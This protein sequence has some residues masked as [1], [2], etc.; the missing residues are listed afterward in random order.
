MHVSTRVCG[1]LDMCRR[2]EFQSSVIDASHVT[3]QHNII[4]VRT[5]THLVPMTFISSPTTCPVTHVSPPPTHCQIKTTCSSG[6]TANLIVFIR[7]MKAVKFLQR[8]NVFMSQ[9]LKYL[10]DALSFEA[11]LIFLKLEQF[12]LMDGFQY[13]GFM[14]LL[15][16]TRPHWPVQCYFEWLKLYIG[17]ITYSPWGMYYVFYFN[18]RI[19]NFPI[20]PP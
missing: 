18:G 7:C 11:V 1:D 10:I 5:S 6:K 9:I 13:L 17:A 8:F 2:G 12:W 15:Y 19:L 14:M 16:S 3:T 20:W 4:T